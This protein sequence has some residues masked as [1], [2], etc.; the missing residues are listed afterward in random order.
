MPRKAK[1]KEI[2]VDIL[3]VNEKEELDTKKSSAV[4]VT[5]K[6]TTKTS[7]TSSKKAGTT[8]TSTRTKNSKKDED[9]KIDI[10]DSNVTTRKRATKVLDSSTDEVKTKTTR[11]SKTST[12]KKST[13]KATKALA[14][15]K[16]SVDT[17]KATSKTTTKRASTS[18]ASSKKAESKDLKANTTK[19]RKTATKKDVKEDISH[20]VSF[21]Y[22]DLPYRYNHTVV[23]LLAQNPNTL[24]VYWDVSD[25]DRQNYINK[26]GENFFY[27]TK[28]ILVVHNLTDKYSFEID[29]N[30]FANNWYIHVEN[31]KCQ[32]V[33]EL[34]RRPI[35]NTE[36]VN[37]D[38]LYVASSNLIES[39]NDHVLFFNENDKIYFKNI[40]TNQ[41]SERVIKPF[42]KNICGIYNNLHITSSDNSFD[43][44]NPSSMNP[45]STFK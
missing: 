7:S 10:K 44:N 42:L 11:T 35:E 22:Y 13:S 5:K 34:G 21:E 14:D 9:D 16:T 12:S 3:N 31:S 23:K 1:E 4:K 40:H 24:F 27:I 45:S 2:N 38:Y 17:K 15:D 28:P 39:P 41:Y 32:Y 8:A 37:E 29:I 20:S 26:Y 30:D 36:N 18:K 33:V 6:T 25:E 43:F 19:T